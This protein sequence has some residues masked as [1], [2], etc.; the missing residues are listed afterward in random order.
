MYFEPNTF[1]IVEYYKK[2]Y[3]K[4]LKLHKKFA[5]LIINILPS[6]GNNNNL[7]RS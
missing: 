5:T 4:Q 6:L 2:K 7:S 1:T 3:R